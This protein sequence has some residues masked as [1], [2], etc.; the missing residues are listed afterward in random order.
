MSQQIWIERNLYIHPKF[1]DKHIFSN[2][3]KELQRSLI[4][5]CTKETGLILSVISIKTQS[6]NKITNI[7]SSIIFNVKILIERIKP[8]VNQNI[9]FKIHKIIPQGLLLNIEDKI[10]VL[11][12][13]KYIP[14]YEYDCDNMCFRNK[15]GKT[16]KINDMV[17]CTIKMVKY[18]CHNFD[19]VGSLK[20]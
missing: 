14:D 18:H 11:I 12:P 10:K 13:S 2:I 20:E 6:N 4:G 3:L 7:N 5:E 15:I 8:E 19:G 16:L 1:L 17:T 9:V